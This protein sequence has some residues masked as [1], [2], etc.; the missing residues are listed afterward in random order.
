MRSTI[1]A[2]SSAGRLVQV[3]VSEG[4]SRAVRPGRRLCLMA[5]AAGL[6]SVAVGCGRV[7]NHWVDDAPSA[8]SDLQS[9]SER[10]IREQ[11]QPA[12]MRQRDWQVA[13]V[14]W[15]SGAVEHG[16]LYFEDP[17]E[18]KGAGRSDYRVGWEDY[19]AFPYT[20]WRAILNGALLPV[21]MVVTPPWT[22]ME[23][24]GVLSKQLLGYDHDAEVK[25]AR[26]A[27]PAAAASDEQGADEPA[28]PG[29]EPEA[30]SETR[31]VEGA[32]GAE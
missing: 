30:E 2:N 26:K 11:Y 12:D 20:F 25:G 6:L 22:T 27:E 31:P 17:F 5:A 3:T 29:E 7:S 4:R 24:D 15:E 18:D 32:D 28:A 1:P 21:S 10:Q 13:S 14:A 9:P 19:V 16:P 8:T 23:S